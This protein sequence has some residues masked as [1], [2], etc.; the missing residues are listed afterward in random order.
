M[1]QTP[2]PYILIFDIVDLLYTSIFVRSSAIVCHQSILYCEL[3][4][5]LYTIKNITFL[6]G[7]YASDPE[8]EDIEPIPL[9]YNDKS[10]VVQIMY[11]DRLAILLET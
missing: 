7:M 8:W 10:P 4:Y 3:R 5:I 11:S 9:P 6:E 1:R 2:D